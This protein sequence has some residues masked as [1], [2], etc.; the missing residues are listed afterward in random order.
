M[1]Q[2]EISITHTGTLLSQISKCWLLRAKVGTAIQT[3]KSNNQ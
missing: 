2:N 3:L 1:P